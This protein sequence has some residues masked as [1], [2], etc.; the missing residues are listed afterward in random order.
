MRTN[1][2]INMRLFLPFIWLMLGLPGS[3]SAQLYCTLS[4]RQLCE[5][6]LQALDQAD[7]ADQDMG[8][9]ALTVGRR[10]MGTPYVGKT[11]EKGEQEQLVVDMEGMDC[12][13]FLENVVVF[14]R[15][16]KLEELNFRAFQR[17]LQKLRYR[18]GLLDG[19]ASRL[20]YF[21]DWIH[22]NERKGI[23]RDV[24]RSLGG[25]RYQKPIN[26][27]SAHRSAYQQLAED[28]YFEAMQKLED[29]INQRT[30]YFIPKDRV[31]AL[32][33]AIQDGDL[34]AIT[35]DI[36]GLDIVHVGVAIHQQGR[37]HLM[38]ASTDQK[39]VVISDKP[40]AEYLRGNRR[41]TGIMVARMVE[42]M[43]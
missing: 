1:S 20:H 13:T 3:L 35:S 38:H 32:G 6:H 28:P 33:S 27:M 25:I 30:R 11:L 10:F 16:V 15:L 41:Q 40:L 21:T 37:L 23:V 17:E 9:L 39:R 42:V 14:S 18:D 43:R 24:T 34:I 22:N 26:F 36:Q 7:L 29:E 19:Y 5:S 31:A 8:T 4:S 2:I 12:T